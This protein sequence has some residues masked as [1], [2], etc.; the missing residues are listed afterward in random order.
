MVT[1]RGRVKTDIYRRVLEYVQA[2][3]EDASLPAIRKALGLSPQLL[4]YY[5]RRL[6]R[7]GYIEV[8]RTYPRFVRITPRG[9]KALYRGELKEPSGGQAGTARV[10]ALQILIPILRRGDNI[11][12]R[13]VK[14]KAWARK[15]LDVDIPDVTI[16]DT[17]KNLRVYVHDLIM[18]RNKRGF[19]Y[20]TQAV[21]RLLYAINAYFSQRGWVLD[22]FHYRVV[23]QHIENLSPEHEKA[24]SQGVTVDL[25][26]PAL[27]ILRREPMNQPAKAWLDASS[28]ILSIETDDRLYEEKLIMMPEH[29]DRMARTVLPLLQQLHEDL[30]LHLE[31]VQQIAMGQNTLNKLLHRL[32][33]LL[34]KLEG[35]L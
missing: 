12:G 9:K 16:E 22:I 4:N 14:M 5:I 35:K 11:S 13:E 26:R 27:D 7:D 28:G 32:N 1:A 33:L 18:P 20:I 2:H 15:V 6:E 3:P 29:V 34:E 8:L 21:T 10:H 24:A 31:A 30:Q 25:G 23:N 19:E 17:G